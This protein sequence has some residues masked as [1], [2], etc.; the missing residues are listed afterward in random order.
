MKTLSHYWGTRRE[1]AIGSAFILLVPLLAAAM[2]WMT[3][4]SVIN[5]GLWTSMALGA[6]AESVFMVLAH[7]KRHALIV[8]ILAAGL[9][10]AP[11][12][13]QAQAVDPAQPI[14]VYHYDYGASVQ[15]SL[16]D[17]QDPE[18]MGIIG[19]GICV[20]VAAG[21]IGYVAVKVISACLK[22]HEMEV[23]NAAGVP[24]MH[25]APSQVPDPSGPIPSTPCDCG[26]A[27]VPDGQPLPLLVEHSFDT[28]HW[29]TIARG[30][31]IGSTFLLPDVGVW[32]IT[33]LLLRVEAK[34]GVVTVHAPP[35]MLEHSQDLRTWLPVATHYS[36]TDLEGQPG[37]YRV[38][39]N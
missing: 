19:M 33:P 12:Y 4:G 34:D 11:G 27:Q 30:T 37:F 1:E 20:G 38:R 7:G 16:L 23:T 5:I 25:Y 8:P 21:L 18:R 14:P 24:F 29:T 17:T 28:N 39:L 15:V 26:A 10:Y 9:I 22:L 2:V 36:D 32:R 3:G 6:L 35:G 31:S 13:A